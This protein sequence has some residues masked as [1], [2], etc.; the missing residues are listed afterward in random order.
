MP[1][2]AAGAVDEPNTDLPSADEAPNAGVV[3]PAA[4]VGVDTPNTEAPAAKAG[5][6]GL[7][8]GFAAALKNGED[9]SDIPPPNAPN[10]EST[11]PKP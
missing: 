8:N 4:A 10:P 6:A 2:A 7:S 1:D 9:V 5:L 11:L 3:E